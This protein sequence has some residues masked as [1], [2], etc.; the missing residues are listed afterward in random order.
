MMKLS[1]Q[2]LIQFAGDL[3]L[4]YMALN[5]NDKAFY[6][7]EKAYEQHDYSLNLAKVDPAFD[8]MRS[9][10][11]FIELLKRMGLEK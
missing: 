11:R 9:D 3:A 1:N 10:P 2:K 7:L 5:D 6:W 8:P 4:L